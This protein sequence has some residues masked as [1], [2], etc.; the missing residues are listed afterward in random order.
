MT[1]QQCRISACACRKSL[2]RDGQLLRRGS[3]YC[4]PEPFGVNFK[5]LEL[6]ILYKTNDI[7]TYN[8][9]SV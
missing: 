9:C 4:V 5:L 6:L 2:N 8:Q 1:Q 7:I 3:L